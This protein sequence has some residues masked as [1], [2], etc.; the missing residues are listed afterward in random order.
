M[1]PW[2]RCLQEYLSKQMK[3]FTFFNICRTVPNSLDLMFP[4]LF[5]EN[6]FRSQVLAAS[7]RMQRANFMQRSPSGFL[8]EFQEGAT[9]AAAAA[10]NVSSCQEWC[11]PN[12]LAQSDR[13]THWQ[14]NY[15]I[16]RQKRAAGARCKAPW[17]LREKA[18]MKA[19]RQTTKKSARARDTIQVQI[20][21]SSQQSLDGPLMKLLWGF[22]PRPSFLLNSPSAS[23]LS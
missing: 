2:K 14:R 21:E 13:P 23:S 12:C 9:C 20:S 6:S 3:T 10:A 11:Y 4:P 5:L 15:E 1:F 18:Q 7:W 22:Q 17:G 16:V 19:E 8:Q